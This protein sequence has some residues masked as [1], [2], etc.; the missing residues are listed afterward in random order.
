[1]GSQASPV[2]LNMPIDEKSKTIIMDEAGSPFGMVHS[3]GWLGFL[4]AISSY[5]EQNIRFLSLH[6]LFTKQLG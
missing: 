5:M 1:M 2:V 6:F 3:F 4:F